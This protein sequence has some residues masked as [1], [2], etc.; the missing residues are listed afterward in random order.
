M[1]MLAP[2]QHKTC[3]LHHAREQ[4]IQ[5]ACLRSKSLLGQVDPLQVQN[6][7]A[8]VGP[9]ALAMRGGDW[10]AADLQA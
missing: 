3:R 9:Q 2:T 5:A 1:H 10:L 8:S 7:P 6:D 4:G